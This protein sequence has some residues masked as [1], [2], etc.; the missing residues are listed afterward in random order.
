MS[1]PLRCCSS[2]LG[3]CSLP[4]PP[5]QVVLNIGDRMGQP[6]RVT[7]RPL[8]IVTAGRVL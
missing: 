3:S 2:S 8:T 1:L 6:S 5:T 7:A 4:V